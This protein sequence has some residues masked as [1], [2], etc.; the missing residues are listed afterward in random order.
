MA[1]EK[2]ELLFIVSSSAFSPVILQKQTG[3]SVSWQESQES[4]AIRQVLTDMAQVQGLLQLVTSSPGQRAGLPACPQL[5]A[6]SPGQLSSVR[7]P[8]P[9][10]IN[11]S[12][13]LLLR[14]LCNY[15]KHA[16]AAH[17][18][19]QAIVEVS[20]M[21]LA[22]GLGEQ[23]EEP[24]LQL[25]RAGQKTSDFRSREWQAD[26]ARMTGHCSAIFLIMG[27]I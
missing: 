23:L 1:G 11:K 9:S 8:S 26:Q 16:S 25:A 5:Y 21:H 24:Q 10:K 17:S 12:F 7:G 2:R 4:W 3:S 13:V 18:H 22:L 14:R 15:S 20:Q 19:A 6:R 27:C